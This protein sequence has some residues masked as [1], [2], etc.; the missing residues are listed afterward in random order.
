MSRAETR[1]ARPRHRARV[2]PCHSGTR[3]T[4]S[5][6]GVGAV[7]KPP[8]FLMGVMVSGT[9]RRWSG[10]WT[11]ASSLAPMATS[12]HPGLAAK[13]AVGED[14]GWL[15]MEEPLPCLTWEFLQGLGRAEEHFCSLTSGFPLPQG[16]RG[17]AEEQG[18]QG[19][20]PAGAGSCCLCSRLSSS[21]GARQSSQG[22]E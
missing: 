11:L 21:P 18:S 9:H 12:L 6:F 2:Q 20:P 8:E 1:C 3:G 10:S 5:R 16:G 15:G 13:A 14:E 7:V 17:A 19:S 4:A 22:F